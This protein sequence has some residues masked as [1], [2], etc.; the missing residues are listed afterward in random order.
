MLKCWQEMS[1]YKQFV[2]EK[3]HSFQLD[4]WGGY[5]LRETLKLM[6]VALKEWYS[7]HAK[8]IPSKIDVLKNR[9]S[10][11]DEAGDEGGLS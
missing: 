4:G 7:V 1:G 8:N 2:K 9:L 6:K 5:V 10:E 3:W 11:L